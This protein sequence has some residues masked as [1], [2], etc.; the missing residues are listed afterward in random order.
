MTA[1]VL[2]V[3][4]SSSSA[5]KSLLTSALCR[6]FTRRGLRVA[7]FKAQNMSNNAA[8]CPDGSE[9]GRAQAVQAAA[10]GLEPSADMN[11]ILIKP[12]ADARSQVIVMGKPWTSL[13]ARAY[14]DHREQLWEIVTQALDRLRSEYDLVIAEGAGSPAELNLRAGDIVNME[15]ALHTQAA[16]LIVGD[17]DRGGIFAQ[18]LGTYWLLA[19]E[20][21]ALIR[22]FVVNKFRGD[23]RLFEDGVKILEQRS[24]LPVLGVIPFLQDHRIPEEDAVV[25]EGHSHLSRPD[26]LIHPHTDIAVIHL[27]RISNFDDFDPLQAEAGV[28]VRFVRT[29][30]ELGH[31]A[32]I[33]LPGTKSTCADLK[34]LRASGLARAVQMHAAAGG[35]IAGICG[36]YQ[37]LGKS[38]N[39]PGGIE[40]QTER[41]SGLG[42]LNIETTFAGQKE[43]SRAVAR[44]TGGPGWL[45]GQ[46]GQTI[47]GYEIHMGRTT[48]DSTWLRISSTEVSG[49]VRAD[50]AANPTGNIWGCYLHGLFD[51]RPFR[52]AWLTSLGWNAGQ[53]GGGSEDWF[54]SALDSLADQ[55]EKAIDMHQ[56]EQIL[57]ES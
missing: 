2:M 9:I 11:P 41:I 23:L 42:L 14:F 46:D 21:Q 50:G 3:V 53:S 39:D 40:S 25:L 10:C 34:W 24:S 37:M 54:S 20:E 35:S 57:W 5:G 17:I 51:N 12:E 18:L 6:I 55:V 8:V 28:R 43:T 45:A 1:R 16:V 13:Q 38:I 36:G 29:P 26:G 52:Q 48:S 30:E 49:P 15:V 27:P 22:G 44:L 32:A 33:I 56:L 47:K 7:P 4:G 19:P 31:P